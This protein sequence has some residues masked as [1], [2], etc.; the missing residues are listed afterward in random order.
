MMTIS[1]PRPT[2]LNNPAVMVELFEGDKVVA[3]GWVF[4]LMAQYNSYSHL[5]YGVTLLPTE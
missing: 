4:E 3:K 5:R 2:E 1:P